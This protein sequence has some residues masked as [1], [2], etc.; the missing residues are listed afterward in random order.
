MF[1]QIGR[2][3]GKLGEY[4]EEIVREVNGDLRVAKDWKNQGGKI[5]WDVYLKYKGDLFGLLVSLTSDEPLAI[6]KSVKDGKLEDKEDKGDADGFK[7]I[8]LLC[9]Q[10]DTKTMSGMLQNFLEVFE[11]KSDKERNGF[12]RGFKKVGAKDS[13]PKIEA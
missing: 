3:D 6:V 5:P 7:A 12:T 8:A 10:Y 9:G 2:I 11:A 13:Q 1:T 4:L